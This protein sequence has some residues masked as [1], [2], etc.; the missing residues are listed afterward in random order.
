V[1]F[2]QTSACILA[3][4]DPQSSPPDDDQSPSCAQSDAHRQDVADEAIAGD[5]S[6]ATIAKVNVE[7]SGKGGFG[8]GVAIACCKVAVAE[9]ALP[10]Y[11]PSMVL[12][13]RPNAR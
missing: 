8:G 11:W 4:S 13:A 12:S 6:S 2:L 7:D 10:V 1:N 9:N 5:D 3:L